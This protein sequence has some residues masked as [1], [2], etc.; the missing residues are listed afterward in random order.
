MIQYVYERYGRHHAAMA[1]EVISY[2]T[3]SAIRDV[4][5][6]LGLSLGQVDA[7]VREYDA[8]ES[9]AGALGAE[10]VD[11]SA[12]PDSVARRRDLD[13]GSNQR[14]SRAASGDQPAATPGRAHTPAS[15]M[16]TRCRATGPIR[17]TPSCPK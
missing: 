1:A 5:K 3:R 11:Y 6:A 7:L 8:R 9:L 16:P 13:A 10:H 2:R 4:G 14:H 17:T 12:L 15:P